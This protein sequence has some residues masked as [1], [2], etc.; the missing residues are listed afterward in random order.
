MYSIK[1]A[2]QAIDHGLKDVTVLYMDIRAF[3]KGFDGF[4]DRTREAGA[5]FI[6]GRPAQ[7]E[8]NGKNI[9]VTYADPDGGRPVAED[10]DMVVLETAAAPSTGLRS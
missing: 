9:Q 6:R 2:Y 4:W 7:I 10:F 5:K 1:H 3:G 8:P